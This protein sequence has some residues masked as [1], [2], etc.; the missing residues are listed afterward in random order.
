M[1]E[2]WRRQGALDR[3]GLAA[4]AADGPSPAG[5]VLS[6]GPAGRQIVLRGPGDH[7][8]F[9][10]ALGQVLG[11][12][13]PVRPNTVAVRPGGAVF[14]LGPT[15]WLVLA[16]DDE[17]GLLPALEAAVTT[18]GGAVVDATGGR[19]ALLV[20]GPSARDVLAQGTPF[21][22]HPR[23]LAD[24][25]CAQTLLAHCPVLLRPLTE[26]AGFEIH[27]PRS[28]ADHLWRWLEEAA[29]EYGWRVGEPSTTAPP[30]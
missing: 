10:E 28:L 24:G 15:E 3:L 11:V 9:A 23:S 30:G 1:V 2:A 22:L 6:P 27:V 16:A 14:W 25:A 7:A 19:V 29:L 5:V 12:P 8:G 21:D 17:A 4:G 20:S 26:P 18:A 13:L